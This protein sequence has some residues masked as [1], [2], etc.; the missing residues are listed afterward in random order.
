MKPED[1]RRI[2]R[3]EQAASEA[4]FRTVAEEARTDPATARRLL[5]VLYSLSVEDRSFA[6]LLH[7][8]I[9]GMMMQFIQ[10][11]AKGDDAYALECGSLIIDLMRDTMR[12][13][14]GKPRSA[15]TA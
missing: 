1:I 6:T 11:R 12:P 15:K 7:L 4:E 13:P 8:F 9:E 10:E 14:R 3:Q 5:A 2:Y